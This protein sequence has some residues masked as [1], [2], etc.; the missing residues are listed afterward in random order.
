MMS[1]PHIVAAD[2]E[3]H[4]L[5]GQTPP[6]FLPLKEEHSFVPVLETGALKIGQKRGGPENERKAATSEHS[7][8][9]LKIMPTSLAIAK[10]RTHSSGNNAW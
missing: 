7:T 8:I 4:G 10:A 3:L 2:N 1:G 9:A 5:H 6:L